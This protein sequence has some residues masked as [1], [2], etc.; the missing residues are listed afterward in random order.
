MFPDAFVVVVLGFLNLLIRCVI[1]PK[2]KDTP[3]T[4]SFESYIFIFLDLL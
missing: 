4:P 2:S 3:I 1:R